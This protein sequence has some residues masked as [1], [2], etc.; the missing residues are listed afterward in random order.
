MAKEETG[1]AWYAHTS[2][3]HTMRNWSRI[4]KTFSDVPDVFREVFATRDEFPYTVFIPEDKLIFQRRRNARLACLLDDRLVVMQ[5]RGNRVR[6]VTHAFDDIYY[7]EY[8][9]ILLYSWLRVVSRAGISTMNFNEVTFHHF[10]PIVSKIREAAAIRSGLDSGVTAWGPGLHCFD[11]LENT[12]YKFMNFGRDS[13]RYGDNVQAV[14][15]QPERRLKTVRFFNIPLFVKYATCQLAVLTGQELIL[16][17]DSRRTKN[18]SRELYGGIFT[19]IPL[20][21][22]RDLSFTGASDE[23]LTLMKIEF[24]NGNHLQME[25][26]AGNPGLTAFRAMYGNAVHKNA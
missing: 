13:V 9:N 25:F 3:D 5:S 11:F 8:G 20:H 1:T 2:S 26:D 14:L 23:S 17:R 10:E 15:Y 19:Y 16:I 21:Q 18:N 4:L 22:V 24:T 6:K 12:S 7:L